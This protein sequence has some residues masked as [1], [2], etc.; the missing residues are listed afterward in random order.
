MIDKP[1][2]AWWAPFT[3]KNKDK[4]ISSVKSQM[5]NINYKYGLE[6]P[7]NATHTYELDKRNKNTI[8]ADVIRK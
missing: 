1:A 5:K 3:L 7:R 8:W 6:V 2:F 4:M